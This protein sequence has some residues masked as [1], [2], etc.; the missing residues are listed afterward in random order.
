MLVPP[1]E[2]LLFF[3]ALSTIFVTDCFIHD[4]PLLIFLPAAD[5]TSPIRSPGVLL[6]LAPVLLLL[7]LTLSALDNVHSLA[8]NLGCAA[9]PAQK[10]KIAVAGVGGYS[11]ACTFGYL[12]RAA[13]L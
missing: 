1:A 7:L 9:K 6:F 4:K 10:K 2:V 8:P 11:G 12:Q 5:A 13:A 3:V